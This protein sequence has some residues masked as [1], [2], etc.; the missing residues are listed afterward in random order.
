MIEITK[1]HPDATQFAEIVC[2]FTELFKK[3]R[4]RKS[5]FIFLKSRVFFFLLFLKSQ[6]YFFIEQQQGGVQ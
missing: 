4:I 5:H 3:N 6:G 1:W 2:W